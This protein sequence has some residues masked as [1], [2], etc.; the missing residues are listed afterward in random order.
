MMMS[1]IPSRSIDILPG[2]FRHL[3]ANRIIKWCSCAR[4]S[5]FIVYCLLSLF[6]CLLYCFIVYCLFHCL[7]SSFHFGVTILLSLYNIVDLGSSQMSA[8]I[9]SPEKSSRVLF[10]IMQDAHFVCFSYEVCRR[11]S[12]PITCLIVS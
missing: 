12:R 5:L 4:A 7:L 8:L 1:Y 2:I 10:S 9:F 3:L 11:S 6:H